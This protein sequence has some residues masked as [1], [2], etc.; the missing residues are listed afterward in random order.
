MVNNIKLFT[1]LRISKNNIYDWLKNP[2]MVIILTLLVFIWNF[3]INPLIGISREIKSPLN[4]SEPFIAVFNSRMLFLIIPEVYLFLISDYP[5]INRNSIF[6]IYRISRKKW[7]ICQFIFFL[8]SSFIFMLLILISTIMMNIKESFVDNG[9]SLVIT[10]YKIYHPEKSQSFAAVL[11]G[12]KLY[13]QITPYSATIHTFCLNWLY[14]ISIGTILL[15]FQVLN[16][17][18]YRIAFLSGIIGIGSAFCVFN[19]KSMWFFPS[20]HAVLSSHF[21]EYL[22]KPVMELTNSYVYFFIFISIMLFISLLRCNCT[23]FL[24]TD[25]E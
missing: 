3:V 22:R 10:N 12:N 16:I 2:R 1:I 17:H 19:V 4:F 5:K 21:T 9:W 20:A 7:V 14:L 13:N 6:I 18:K 15:M 25:D 23:N 11:I 24:N 8:L